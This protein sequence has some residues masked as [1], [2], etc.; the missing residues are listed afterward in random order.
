LLT[1]GKTSNT[2]DYTQYSTLS[3]LNELNH[4]EQVTNKVRNAS[5]DYLKMKNKS[6]NRQKSIARLLREQRLLQR[7]KLRIARKGKK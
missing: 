2:F 5:K 4:P 6:S 3:L 7:E 1:T